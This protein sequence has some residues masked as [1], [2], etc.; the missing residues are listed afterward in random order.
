MRHVPSP[1]LTPRRL[2]RLRPSTWTLRA[3]LIAALVGLLAVVCLVVAVAT[4]LAMRQ[5]LIQRLDAQVTAAGGRASDVGGPSHE[6]PPG[7]PQPSGQSQ[8]GD[9]VGAN[10]LIAPGQAT[11]TL[12][13][14]IVGGQVTAAGVL[15]DAS[16]RPMIDPL[17]AKAA[18]SL[19]AVTPDGRIRTVQVGD[20]GSYR[21]RAITA[22]D[23]DVILT[24]L[25]LSDVDATVY[26]LV[27][28]EIA[29]ALIGLL[30]ATL[31]G[32]II[33][34]R[35]LRPLERV[36]ATATRVSQ[37]QLDRGEVEL[38][39]RVPD[40][41]TDPRTEVGQVATALNHLLSHVGD[42]LSARH[43]SESRVRK[44]VADASHELRTPLSAIRG[45]TE[46]TRRDQG[47]FSPDVSY[48]LSRV[49]SEAKRMSVLVEDLLLLARLDSGRPLEM[50][51]LDLTRSVL[52]AV[53]DASAAGPD[54][55]WRL[56]LPDEPVT[57]IGDNDRLHQ[58]LTNLLANARTHTPAG[59]T[60]TARL[61]QLPDHVELAV[62]DDGPGISADLLPEVFQRFARGD[63][64]RARGAGSTGLGLAIVDAVVRAHT[65]TV[66]VSSR[67]G[68]TRFLVRLPVIAAGAQT[69]H[70]AVTT[71]L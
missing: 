37:L 19:A 71:A 34:R 26:R 27:G 1:R 47:S 33:V 15:V 36:A 4:T 52:D 51:E 32:I 69:R 5:F 16:P 3:R 58:V 13:G 49:D 12:G 11:G 44:F 62:T 56:D 65:G 41:D 61:S 31:A 22:S 21:I 38:S 9:D 29:V 39:D 59:T 10:F 68:Q 24:G 66:S 2:H 20:L 35:S 48:A 50:A 28:A 46:L 54:H 6:E 25:P 53:S 7:Q 43:A 67:P 42:A 63:N 18:H 45:Y 64:S 23:G 60:V 14:R 40:A 70:S 55:R 57:V 8:Y 17:D 30:V